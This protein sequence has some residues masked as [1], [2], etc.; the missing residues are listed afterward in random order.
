MPSQQ[1]SRQRVERIL[2]AAGD[3]VAERGYEATTTSLIAR[4]ARVSPGSFYQ[5]FA[6]KRAAV[7]AL[8]ARN[9]TVFAERLDTMLAESGYENWW[10][11]VEGAFDIYVDL[12]RH[13]PGF[14]AVRFGDI[15]DTH[16]LDPT[17][18]NDSVLAGRVATLLHTRFGVVDT[19]SLRLALLTTTK[20]A[21]ALIKF[22]FSRDPQ[23]DEEVLT[24]GRRMLRIHLEGYVQL[25]SRE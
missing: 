4:R 21:D 18:D 12:C 2:D 16:L 23:G 25:G 7:K 19:P 13:H 14:R 6:D 24:Q 8:S 17:Q 5:F 11:T 1:R 3:L 22:A 9:M 20:V 15:V 10:A